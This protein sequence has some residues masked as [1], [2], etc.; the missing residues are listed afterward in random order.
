[1]S[2]IKQQEFMLYIRFCAA[3][4]C[5]IKVLWIYLMYTCY[6]LQLNGSRFFVLSSLTLFHVTVMMLILRKHM[7][8][9][10]KNK[11]TQHTLVML[12][13]CLLILKLS[14]CLHGL[15][16]SVE[17]VFTSVCS[18]GTFKHSFS[19]TIINDYDVYI[20]RAFRLTRYF[21]A[22]INFFLI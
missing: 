4:V 10:T 5:G 22:S 20:F 19:S 21:I 15:F 16:L 9:M 11:I 6:A 3:V 13:K 8:N 18:H 17:H 14:T 2:A 1:M 12:W 7:R